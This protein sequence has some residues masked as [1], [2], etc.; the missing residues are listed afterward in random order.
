MNSPHFLDGL[1]LS[2][3]VGLCLS[4]GGFRA[5]LFHLGSLIRLNE[6]GWLTKLDRV[7]SVSGGSIV[8]AYLG[9]RWQELTFE[10]Q[11]AS[12]FESVVVQPIREFCG[13]TIDRQAIL[14]SVLPG[15]TGARRLSM[16]YGELFGNSKLGDHPIEPR[17]TINATNLETG[18]GVRLSAKY[19]AD[20][21][22]GKFDASDF[23][24]RDVVAA[25]SA[26]PPVLSPVKFDLR[27]VN[28]ISTKYADMHHAPFNE[29]ALVTDGGVYDNLGSETV[30]KRYR[31]ILLSNAGRPLSDS[32]SVVEWWFGKAMEAN[33]LIHAQSER[34]RVRVLRD[35]RDSRHR[36]VAYWGLDESL[37]KFPGATLGLT[38]S[39]FKDASK[40]RTRLNRFTPTEQVRLINLGYVGTDHAMRTRL[41][42]DLPPVTKLPAH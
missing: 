21:R 17:F 12:N 34:M 38:P 30:W 8:S 9:M 35:L 23:L 39:D 11:V 25:S 10:N 19:G 40:I 29:R 4:G 2:E 3:G 15:V 1:K 32:P 22:I 33:R 24:L 37:E 16:A 26:F 7:S 42:A 14:A 41:T 20:H 36:K 18:V 13:H 6:I 31:T 28:W 27:D 5:T